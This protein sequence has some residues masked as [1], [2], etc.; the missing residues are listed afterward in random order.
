VLRFA[1]APPDFAVARFAVPRLAAVVRFAAA[2]PD[3]AVARFAVVRPDAAVRFA[4]AP[5][6][7]AVVARDLVVPRLAAVAHFAVPRLAAVVRF[8][9]APLDFVAARFAVAR[10]RDGPDP[11]P[12]SGDALRPLPDLASCLGVGSPT[13]DVVLSVLTRSV[14]FAARG[15]AER[16]FVVR[17]FCCWRGVSARVGAGVLGRCRRFST[18][19]TSGIRSTAAAS[20]LSFCAVL[21]VP[22]RYTTPSTVFTATVF[23]GAAESRNTTVSTLR[24][25]VTSLRDFGLAGCARARNPFAVPPA[26]RA[27]PPAVPATSRASLPAFSIT[28]LAFATG[29]LLTDC[30]SSLLEACPSSPRRNDL[31]QDFLQVQE[32]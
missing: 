5:L 9:A 24:A 4:L 15:E 22:R 20:A 10:L 12:P 26:C 6:D 18:R 2:P 1:V 29:R 21:T 14:R 17:V 31:L 7:F 13:R 19:R 16:G 30:E 3:F 25:S 28:L 11:F 32:F 8:A 23:F 27:T